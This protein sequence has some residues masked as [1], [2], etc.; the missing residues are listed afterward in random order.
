M[1]STDHVD[2]GLPIRDHH[3]VMDQDRTSGDSAVRSIAD[4][5]S[6]VQ[7]ETDE[8]APPAHGQDPAGSW[9]GKHF[10]NIR[11]SI[12]LIFMRVYV[13]LVAGKERRSKA[14]RCAERQKHPLGTLGN[15]FIFS[16]TGT[17]IGLACLAVLIVAMVLVIRQ[18]FT[19]DITL[20]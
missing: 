13:T 10:I 3:R 12:P 20:R 1:W 7:L 16:T 5:S 8:A 11:L 14:R 19:V 18:L 17:V 6:A 15:A 9:D 4:P 2:C